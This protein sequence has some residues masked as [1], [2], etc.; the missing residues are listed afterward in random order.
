MQNQMELTFSALPQNEAFAR[1]AIAAFAV[2]NALYTTGTTVTLDGVALATVA[3]PEEA[4]AARLT[5][6]TLDQAARDCEAMKA[7]ARGR[8]DE[9]ARWIAEKVVR[10]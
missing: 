8:L 10:R 5:R 4:E 3:S 2:F 9:T 7:E 6:E 1:V